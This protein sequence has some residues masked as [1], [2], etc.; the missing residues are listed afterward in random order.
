MPTV[1]YHVLSGPSLG[2][3][4]I[5][6][7]IWWGWWIDLVWNDEIISEGGGGGGTGT[8]AF[9]C[10]RAVILCHPDTPQHP[11]AC[12]LAKFPGG[13]GRPL[14]ITGSGR[15]S[16]SVFT[17]E[18]NRYEDEP[19]IVYTFEGVTKLMLPQEL[20]STG[21]DTFMT[22]MRTGLQ[23]SPGVDT[24]RLEAFEVFL[25]RGVGVHPGT[26]EI[27]LAP[28]TSN[29]LD[30]VGTPGTGIA[31]PGLDA[32]SQPV[33]VPVGIFRSARFIGLQLFGTN[34]DSVFRYLGAILRGR[35]LT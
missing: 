25:R 19:V 5:D 9:D 26:K 2:D 15:I 11:P 20:Q 29:V 10:N 14:K 3:I 35:R 31:I 12:F 13:G 23:P 16:E 6:D 4:W 28:V 22:M 33:K 27:F 17:T 34:V 8:G 7:W 21:D 18:P 32:T 24:H 1:T 30:E